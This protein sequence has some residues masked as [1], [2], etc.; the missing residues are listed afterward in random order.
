MDIVRDDGQKA[1][2]NLQV[3]ASQHARVEA[4]IHEMREM[5]NAKDCE[6][7]LLVEA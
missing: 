7:V 3:C 1:V 6:A 4:A 5:Y 2:G